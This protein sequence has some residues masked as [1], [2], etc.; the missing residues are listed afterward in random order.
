MEIDEQ[1]KQLLVKYDE[2]LEKLKSI[3]EKLDNLTRNSKK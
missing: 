2:L 3:D 1:I